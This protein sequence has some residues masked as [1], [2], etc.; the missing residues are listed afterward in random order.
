MTFH[1]KTTTLV[2]YRGKIKAA[3]IG[4]I[5]LCIGYTTVEANGFWESVRS[6]PSS[7]RAGT[8]WF[9]SGSYAYWDNIGY[10][11]FVAVPEIPK[12]LQPESKVRS[13]K[14]TESL[15]NLYF[16]GAFLGN[17]GK[18]IDGSFYF[19]PRPGGHNGV[20]AGYALRW[21]ADCLDNLNRPWDEQVKKTLDKYHVLGI[22]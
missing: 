13:E 4:D 9:E 17:A 22:L 3:Q 20:W 19:I 2:N 21:V 6:L 1:E 15:Y 8:I 16:N 7:P 12:E 5:T 10:W 18:E 14:V 11:D